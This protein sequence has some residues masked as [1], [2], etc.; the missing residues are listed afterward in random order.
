MYKSLWQDQPHIYICS[1]PADESIFKVDGGG[2]VI[3]KEPGA[4]E[5]RLWFW[6]DVYEHWNYHAGDTIIVEVISNLEKLELFQ[7]GTSLGWK[8]LSDFPDRIYKWSV[9]YEPGEIEARG[10]MN[11]SVV[12]HSIVTAG[13]PIA[14]ELKI[15][16]PVLSA[17][18]YAVA[19]AVVQLIDGKGHPVKAE[20]RRISFEITGPVT[21]KGVDNGSIKSTQA[22]QQNSLITHEG[23]ALCI[24]QSGK[25]KGEATLTVSSDGLNPAQTT[26]RLD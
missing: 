17:D 9:I 6:H 8:Q 12:E 7:N 2:E 3:E 20:E 25:E 15:D 23:R 4:W 5:H 26:M 11:G 13:D 1:N 21:L 14:L 19:H 24:L 22:Y 10:E 18:G 16:T